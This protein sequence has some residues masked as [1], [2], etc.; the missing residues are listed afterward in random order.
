MTNDQS[1]QGFTLIDFMI[2]IAIIG[3]LA[4]IAI[5]QF[6]AYKVRGYNVLAISDIKNASIAQ[7]AYYADHQTYTRDLGSLINYGFRQT[8]GV[9]VDVPRK[10]DN[11][12]ILT[13]FHDS[14]DTAY[15]LKGPGGIVKSD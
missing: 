9:T 14:G 1:V 10:G 3:I 11:E 8:Q 15:T 12:Y 6:L 4:A 2:V 5:P 13:A 7:E